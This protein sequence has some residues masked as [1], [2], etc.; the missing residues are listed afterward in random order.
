MKI[1][2]I[3]V[4]ILFLVV[5]YGTYND[6]LLTNNQQQESR[7]FTKRIIKAESNIGNLI[8][9]INN[10]AIDILEIENKLLSEINNINNK[11]EEHKHE[12]IE[13]KAEPISLPSLD[14]VRTYDP[15]ITTDVPIIIE[16]ISEKIISTAV[17]PRPHSELLPFLKK[18]S[19]RRDYKFKA[20][21]DII[22]GTVTN[23]KFSTSLPSKLKKAIGKYLNSLDMSNDVRD[24][25]VPFKLLR[26]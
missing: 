11:L 14:L 21:Y 24:C 19:L 1:E 26:D 22:N 16:Q 25:Y 23:L 2:H 9:H 5:G 12:V 20:S 6:I 18:V 4:G 10:D 7:D 15:V 17:C 13:I 8:E 3:L